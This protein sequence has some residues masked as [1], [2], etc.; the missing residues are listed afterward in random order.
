M[1]RWHHFRDLLE[2]STGWS[3]GDPRGVE[4]TRAP[5][6]LKLHRRALPLGGLDSSDKGGYRSWK[7]RSS[8]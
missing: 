4:P 2:V 5:E 7:A 8:T 1:G 6:S 3:T